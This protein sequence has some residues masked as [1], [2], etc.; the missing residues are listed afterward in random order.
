[1]QQLHAWTP[2]YRRQLEWHETL[3]GLKAQGK[4]RA[5]GISA[6]D[7]DP[8]GPVELV[9]S[10][11]I[12]S[13]QVIYNIF[14]QRPAERLLPEALAHGVGI[15]VRLPFEEGLLTGKLGP[16]HRFAEG[17]W[18]AEWLTPDRLREAARRVDEL[19]P[20]LGDEARDLPELALKY[21]LAHPA[22]STVIPGM[23]SAEHVR[24]NCAASGGRPLP[25]GTLQALQRHAFT[26]GWAYP[27]S[28]S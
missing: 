18:R 19:R 24:Q 7:W 11:L 4:V 10:G 9:R 2:P 26:H 21:C 20:L 27:W 8:Y 15:I 17:D 16:D 13:V 1:V 12:D 28:Q 5:F 3:G 22:V 23:R 14:E 6:N 25:P